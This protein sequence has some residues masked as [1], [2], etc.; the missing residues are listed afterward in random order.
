MLKADLRNAS[1]KAVI[2]AFDDILLETEPTLWVLRRFTSENGWALNVRCLLA[3]LDI[4][5]QKVTLLCF[6]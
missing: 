2:T 4:V 1:L 3:S 5:V 6:I